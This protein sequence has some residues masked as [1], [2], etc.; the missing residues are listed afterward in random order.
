MVYEIV[1]LAFLMEKRYAPYAKWLGTAFATLKLSAKLTPVLQAV[2]AAKTW[3]E[4]ERQLAR[5]YSIVARRHNALRITEPLPTNVTRYYNRPYFVIHGDAFARAI[6][7]AITDRN[8]KRLATDAG[9]IDQFIDS[10]DLLQQL[11]LLRRLRM[12]YDS[13]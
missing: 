3:K 13:R 1:K 12:V 11:S 9:S 4:R 7:D 2:L 5:A 10:H 6:R 8:V